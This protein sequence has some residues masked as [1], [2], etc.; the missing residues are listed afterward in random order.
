MK[1][2]HMREEARKEAMKN[3]INININ[4]KDSGGGEDLSKPTEEIP[5]NK[6]E[7]INEKV[8]YDTQ[9]DNQNER[10]VICVS[11]VE[12]EI[13]HE[14]PTCVRVEGSIN[15]NGTCLLFDKR[16]EVPVSKKIPVRM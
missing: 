10:C 15:Q 3:I 16:K 14:L 11:Y 5:D 9:T 2:E 13:K 8:M 12:P 6:L 7:K 1:G 4:M